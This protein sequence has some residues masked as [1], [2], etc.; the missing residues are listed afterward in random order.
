[1]KKTTKTAGLFAKF[2]ETARKIERLL[3]AFEDYETESG[4]TIIVDGEIAVD[5]EA[6]VKDAET[7]EETP[8]SDGDYKLTSDGRTV[9]VKDGIIVEVKEVSEEEVEMADAE[10]FDEM[11]SQMYDLLWKISERVQ[12]LVTEV[13]VLKDVQT[14]DGAII[15]EMQDQ[16]RKWGKAPAAST[17]QR[18]KIE[19]P[20]KMSDAELTPGQR[21]Q[22]RK[23]ESIRAAKERDRVVEN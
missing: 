13:G 21:L 10:T 17:V 11:M 14:Q 18:R 3:A 1:M 22:M 5:K 4:V 16:V 20:A 6:K 7:E 15:V 23:R 12:A 2:A 8:A 19:A 9:V